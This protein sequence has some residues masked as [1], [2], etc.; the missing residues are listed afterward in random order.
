M[1]IGDQ[2]AFPRKS[3]EGYYPGMT[4]RQWLVGMIASSEGSDGL[5][6]RYG[7]SEAAREIIG[8]ADAI[9]NGLEREK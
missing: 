6:H 1:T 7:I 3:M 8:R 4:Y 5:W 2:P 9:I